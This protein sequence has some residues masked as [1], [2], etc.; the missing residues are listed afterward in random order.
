MRIGDCNL[1]VGTSGNVYANTAFRKSALVL[2]PFGPVSIILAEKVAKTSC[3]LQ[4]SS[5]K[6]PKKAL[7]VQASKCDFKKSSGHFTPFFWV[8]EAGE[9]D[10]SNL[11]RGTVKHE[12]LTIPCFRNKVA[13]AKGQRLLLEASEPQKRAKK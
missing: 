1:A 7:V 4:M 8:R 11:Q 12:E 5:L 10:E 3:V 2:L 9:D 6:Q 13:L